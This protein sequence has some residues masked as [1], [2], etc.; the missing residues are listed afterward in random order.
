MMSDVGYE[1]PEP[2][3]CYNFQNISNRSVDLTKTSFASS[4]PESK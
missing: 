4:I 3:N 2:E 1:P